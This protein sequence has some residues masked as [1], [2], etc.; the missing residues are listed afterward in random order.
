[1]TYLAQWRLDLAADLIGE[2]EMTLDAVAARVG[3]GSGFALSVAFKRV[4]G[5]SPAEHRAART[6]GASTISA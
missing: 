1:M 5:I 4:K 3:Y 6:A 2:G